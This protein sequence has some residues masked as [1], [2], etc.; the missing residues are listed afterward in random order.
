MTNRPLLA[1]LLCLLPFGI[2]VALTQNPTSLGD[3]IRHLT[4]A[5]IL[6]QEGVYSSDG[7]GDYLFTGYFS[8]HSSD[9]WF[10]SH[11]VLIPLSA[12]PLTH[13]HAGLV[14]LSILSIALSLLLIFRSWKLPPGTQ[15]VLLSLLIL[16]NTQFA[17]RITLGRPVFLMVALTLWVIYA[18]LQRKHIVLCV[19]LLLATLL[20]HLFVFPLFIVL[21]GVAWF[22]TNGDRREAVSALLWS[23]IGVVVGILIHP[24]SLPYLHYLSNVFFVIPFLS[25]SLDLGTEFRSESLY[26][27]LHLPFI[28]L[29][30]LTVVSAL[31]KR[32]TTF[33]DIHT[34][35]TTFLLCVCLVFIIGIYSWVR[36]VDF[37]WPLVVLL[38][39][40]ICKTYPQS[41][42]YTAKALLPSFALQKNVLVP[43]LLL[44]L[45]VT[46][47][48]VPMHFVKNDGERN[49]HALSALM[50]SIEPGARIFNVDWDTMPGLFSQRPDL[51]YAR[52][53]D[54]TF[55]Y[56]WDPDASILL[57]ALKSRERYLIDWDIWREQITE[58]YESDYIVIRDTYDQEVYEALSGEW[59]RVEKGLDLY[60]YKKGV[61]S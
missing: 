25:E 59:E 34:N 45:I 28:A 11:I 44:V 8:D 33:E 55:D 48:K 19:L 47:V 24:H 38:L 37:A 4:H 56:V 2:T 6:S 39:G 27:T 5:Q 46:G 52:G 31:R 29:S 42:S 10:L 60:L 43:V 49:L 17:L 23:A 32:E 3:G 35:A 1:L 16:G 30:G 50:S 15:A 14:L 58:K 21:T 7:W 20:S 41:V 57:S 40:F 12:L 61:E 53:M 13:G 36:F 26:A 51:L 22:L 9:P 18:I 54:P